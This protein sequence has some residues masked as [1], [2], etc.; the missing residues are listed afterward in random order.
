MKKLIVLSMVVAMA[1]L[2]TAGLSLSLSGAGVVDT[3]AGT[4]TMLEGS[5]AVIT[6]SG[7]GSAYYTYLALTGDVAVT[8]DAAIA[9]PVALAGAGDM[10]S[11]GSSY[12]WLL[13]AAG[14]PAGPVAAGA[15]FTADITATG[16]LDAVIG[17]TTY[18]NTGSNPG[19]AI[20]I[21]P[22]PMTLGLLGLGGL[23]LRRK[24]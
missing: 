12:G 6:V 1:S 7:S 3:G 10:A 23:F 17:V 24:K 19:M 18:S 11:V 5:T 20:T 22:E 14:G 16:P 2:A 21:V 9:T 13:T 8:A 4:Y 15:Q